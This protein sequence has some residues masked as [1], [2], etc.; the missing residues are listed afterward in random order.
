MAR[1]NKANKVNNHIDNVN[2]DIDYDKLAEAIVKAQRLADKENADDENKKL[3][4]TKSFF[5]F[6]PVST[7][8]LVSVISYLFIIVSLYKAF[9]NFDGFT[10]EFWGYISI[11]I[12]AMI[13][14]F[15]SGGATYEIYNLQDFNQ[16]I[17]ISSSI[18]SI[19]ATI[20]ALA[21]LIVTVR[22]S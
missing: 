2:I 9:Y 16:I 18:T 15:I 21:T 11:A 4:I 7:L 6:I 1:K 3:P 17:T 12:T 20:I 8:C 5:W 14:S 10:D 13:L 19:I 22:M